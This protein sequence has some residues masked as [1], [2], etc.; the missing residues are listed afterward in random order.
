MAKKMEI[1]IIKKKKGVRKRFALHL[2]SFFQH[3]K[4]QLQ[5]LKRSV[6]PLLCHGA[7]KAL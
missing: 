2:L 3:P 6:F 1:L 4:A 5:E 7:V